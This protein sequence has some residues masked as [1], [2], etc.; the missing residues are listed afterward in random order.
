MSDSMFSPE[1][2]PVSIARE[3]AVKYL[4]K[5]DIDRIYY[6]SGVLFESHCDAYGLEG[7]VRRAAEELTQGALDHLAEIDEKISSVSAHWSLERMASTDRSALRLACYELFFKKTPPKV[8]INEC[9]EIAKKYG[10]GH[11]GRFVNGIL[12][13]LV[14]STPEL[15]KGL[16]VN[17]SSN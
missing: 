7:K 13:A 8:V 14:K 11:S 15:A 6:Y 16:S 4:Y 17:N 5:C 10:S 2:L 3:E 9:I 12:D 1:P